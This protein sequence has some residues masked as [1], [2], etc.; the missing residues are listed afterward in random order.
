MRDVETTITI[1][2]GVLRLEPPFVWIRRKTK[3]GWFFNTEEYFVHTPYLKIQ[4]SNMEE[5]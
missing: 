2:W 3:R 4:V 5:A 1:N